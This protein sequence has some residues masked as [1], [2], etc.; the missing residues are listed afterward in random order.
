[1]SHHSKILHSLIFFNSNSA[2]YIVVTL[3][4]HND[5]NLPIHEIIVCC[6]LALG[7]IFEQPFTFYKKIY[8]N[9]LTME[10]K[11]DKRVKNTQS[12]GRYKDPRTR[13]GWGCEYSAGFESHFAQLNNLWNERIL[14]RVKWIYCL[15]WLWYLATMPW[16]FTYRSISVRFHTS[17]MLCVQFYNRN[18]PS[19]FGLLKPCSHLT[20]VYAFA[21]KF[22]NGIYGNKWLRWYLTLTFSRTG[23]QWSKK[24]VNADVT[25]EWTLTCFQ[26]IFFTPRKKKVGNLSLEKDVE[27]SNEGRLNFSRKKTFKLA[28]FIIYLE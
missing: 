24:I 21:S 28:P 4:I 1:M 8:M 11:C 22:R 13:L 6:N 3:W 20:S 7:D 23:R 19:W 18:A 10:S 12:V 14:Y 2:E 9:A 25:C 15:L 16:S 27:A 17:S 26:E 5:T